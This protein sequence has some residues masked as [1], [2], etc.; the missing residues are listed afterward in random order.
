MKTKLTAMIALIS[1][2]SIAFADGHASG[3]PAAG[4]EVFRQCKSCHSIKDAD[5]NEI[6][7]GGKVGPNLYGVAG[8]TTGSVDG[9]NYSKPMI[10]AGAAGL[11]WDEAQFVPYV[12]DATGFLRDYLDDKKARGKMTYRVRKEEDAINVWA[13][14][15]SVGGE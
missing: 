7:K 6:Q 10:A 11:T 5:G 2:G 3:D 14:L 1:T 13:Y 8:R 4:E 15:V 12:Q 9:F